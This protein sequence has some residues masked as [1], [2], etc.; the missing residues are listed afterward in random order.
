MGI[1]IDIEW[2]FVSPLLQKASG[3]LTIRHIDPI[4][5][6]GK[7]VNNDILLQCECNVSQGALGFTSIN[8]KGIPSK[9]FKIFEDQIH[10]MI[11][12]FF[13]GMILEK[14]DF[15][16]VEE[17]LSDGFDIDKWLMDKAL[18]IDELKQKK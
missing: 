5:P 15:H 6:V 18:H 9:I 14:S 13:K 4:P 16:W 17:T 7:E 10:C 12:S 8:K 2:K 11:H 3:I 1:R